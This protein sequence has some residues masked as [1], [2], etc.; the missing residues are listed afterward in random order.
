MV[1]HM[2]NTIRYHDLHRD[3]DCTFDV[4]QHGVLRILCR[5]VESVLCKGLQ[6]VVLQ[7]LHDTD[8]TIMVSFRLTCVRIDRHDVLG[9]CIDGESLVKFEVR[10][11]G[12]VVRPKKF[13][14]NF[15][16]ILGCQGK[17]V[18]VLEASLH[19]SRKWGITNFSG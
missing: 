18:V 2:D 1:I 12:P 8:D 15:V 19:S 17:H 11:K 6:E 5:Q 14:G 13:E 16:P 3:H 10:L 4:L 9:T 7:V